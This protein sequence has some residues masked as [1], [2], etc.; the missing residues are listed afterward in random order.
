MRSRGKV[1]FLQILLTG[2]M[3]AMN[4]T[5]FNNPL[6]SIGEPPRPNM[7]QIVAVP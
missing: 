7:R 4:I 3:A 1:Q 2:E 6:H 5:P